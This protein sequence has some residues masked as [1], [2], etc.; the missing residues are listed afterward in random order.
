MVTIE[1]ALRT[2]PGDSFVQSELMR[3]L[4]GRVCP[5]SED[6]CLV[7]SG[8]GVTPLSSNRVSLRVSMKH[9]GWLFM[10][11][12]CSMESRCVAYQVVF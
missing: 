12:F 2:M 11:M 10:V 7:K 5:L 4:R 9:G 6:Q 3:N 8:G 1:P